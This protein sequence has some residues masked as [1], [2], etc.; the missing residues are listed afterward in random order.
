MKVKSSD[1]DSMEN[2][3]LQ[4]FGD[5][6]RTTSTEDV[7]KALMNDKHENSVDIL[8]VASEEQMSLLPLKCRMLMTMTG[9]FGKLQIK[10][11]NNIHNLKMREN[12]S[13]N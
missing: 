11:T 7:E 2:G 1:N 13:K 5:A 6:I 4:Q 12:L 9:V 3:C 8:K 10:L